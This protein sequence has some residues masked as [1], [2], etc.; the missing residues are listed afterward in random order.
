MTIDLDSA[1]DFMAGHARMLDRRRFELLFG[2]GGADAVLAAVNAYR[3]A[4]GGYGWGLEPDLRA[5]ESQP[6][7]ALHAFEVF[8]ELAPAVVPEAAAVCDWLAS[9]SLP[10]GGLPFALQV[11]NPTG[12]A[13]FWAE[14]DASRSSLHITAAVLV[15]AYRVA[16]HDDAVAAHPWLAS[17]TAFCL[18]AIGHLRDAPHAI[19]LMYVLQLLEQ[20]PAAADELVRV[21]A[22]LPTDATVHV[23]GGLEDEFLRPLDFSPSPTGALREHIDANAIDV[24][25]DRVAGL[26]QADGGWVVDFTSYSP[27]AALEWRGYATVHSLTILRDNARL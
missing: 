5:V 23:G 18:D 10:D 22:F 4:D 3:N 6:G 14:A 7:G 2:D 8:G 19:E 24:D 25:L 20:V 26:Q 17:A 11:A 1:A 15:H 9:V 21:Q 27:A 16:R 13:P 12:C